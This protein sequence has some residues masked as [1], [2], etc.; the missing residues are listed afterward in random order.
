MS[1][2]SASR[3][4]LRNFMARMPSVSALGTAG[5]G[6]SEFHVGD[7]GCEIRQLDGRLGADGVDKIGFDAPG[8]R[9]FCRD[10]NFFEF[11]AAAALAAGNAVRGK[12]VMKDAFRTVK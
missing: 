3:R 4:V 2:R 10:R 8:T 9:F 1:R 7:A 6:L 11:C 12:I 5:H